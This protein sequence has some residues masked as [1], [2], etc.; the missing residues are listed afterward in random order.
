MQHKGQ[1]DKINYFIL[2]KIIGL[3]Q[4]SSYIK[5]RFY[6]IKSGKTLRSKIVFLAS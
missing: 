1:G 2:S 5:V 4:D 6:L 3:S